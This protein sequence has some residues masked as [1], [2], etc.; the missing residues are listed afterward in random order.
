MTTDAESKRPY[1][2]RWKPNG[3]FE[4]RL[5]ERDIALFRLLTRYVY[6]PSDYIVAL[7][8][9]DKRTWQDRLKHLTG[10]GY[11]ARPKQQR[12]HSNANCRPL[13]Y[14]L[15][16]RGFNA[17]RERGVERERPRAH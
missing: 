15:A 1:A 2:S 7:L 16:D 13:V 10:G 14:A 6:L 11:L 17:L 4:P 12:Q 9:G 3:D 5:G 8:R